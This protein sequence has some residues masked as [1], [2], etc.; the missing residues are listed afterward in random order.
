MLSYSQF[1]TYF[2]ARFI[3]F[4]EQKLI[5]SEILVHHD[6]AFKHQKT[7]IQ[8]L[9]ASGKRIRPYIC[10]GVLAHDRDHITQDEER[11]LFAIELFHTFALIHDDCI[12]G[13]TTRRGVPT[14]HHVHGLPAG[15]LWGDLLYLFAHE[16]IQTL[17]NTELTRLFTQM[18]HETILGQMLDVY[19]RSND[20]YCI[21][22]KTAQ[23]TVL[24]PVLIA[25]C[26]RGFPPSPLLIQFCTCVG[27]L[28]QLYDDYHDAETK[29]PEL[30]AR[31]SKQKQ[32]CH[33]FLGSLAIPK[34]HQQWW[35]VFL[36]T[37]FVV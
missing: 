14:M 3:E 1:Q 25:Y 19:G 26:V 28:F 24:Y 5:E 36:D 7:I 32:K 34:T 31:L 17:E 13:D 21:V 15:I 2:N 9:I 18:S 4:V 35:R 12:D 16:T 33:T 37:T 27:V 23:Y 29:T 22:L 10:Y 20:T 30:H 11:L 6:A 8:N